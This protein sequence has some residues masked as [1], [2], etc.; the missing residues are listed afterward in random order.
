MK[1]R[2]CWL[3]VVLALLVAGL[4]LSAQ[5]R[6]TYSRGQSVSPAFEGWWQN[7]D[8]TYSLFFGYMNSNWLE[9]FDVPVG[10][11]NHIEP[12]GPDRGQPTHFYPRRNLFLFTVD[13]PADF[14][15]QEVVWTL[16]TNGVTE[17]A[18]G[19]LR[20]DYLLDPQTIGTEMGANFGGVIDE[21]RDNEFPNLDLAVDQPRRVRV[22]E[23]LRLVAFASDDGIPSGTYEPPAVE[24]GKPHPAYRAPRQIVPGNPPGLRFAW[25]VYRGD[26]SKVTFYPEQLKM[27]QD[28]R[29]YANSPWSFPYLIPPV[30]EDGRFETAVTFD[31][32]GTYVLRA[33]AGDGALTSSEN[34]MITVTR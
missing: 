23:P 34:L 8:G 26:A 22:G 11:D 1:K 6:F 7:E 24:A 27:W 10:P 5:T 33:L 30:P 2:T 9:E 18:Y 17:R 25:I 31:E 19:S 13:V 20:T 4:G 14:G 21:W 16:T 32:P 28:T 15:E 29:V 12:G 3:L